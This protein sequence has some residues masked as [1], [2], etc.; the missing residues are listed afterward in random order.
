MR[1][2]YSCTHNTASPRLSVLLRVSWPSESCTLRRSRLRLLIAF[3]S[4]PRPLLA[5]IKPDHYIILNELCLYELQTNQLAL[6]LV[7]MF[8]NNLLRQPLSPHPPFSPLRPRRVRCLI[9]HPRHAKE[10]SQ[11]D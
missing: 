5:P 8:F 10:Q 7:F 11:Q 9:I 4:T 2:L 1:G 6:S 3:Y